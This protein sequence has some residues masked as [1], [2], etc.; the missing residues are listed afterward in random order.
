M[1]GER[2]IVPLGYAAFGFA[3]GVAAGMIIRRTLPAMATTL[4]LFLGVRIAFTYLIRSHLLAP[5]HRVVPLDPANMGFGSSNGGPDNLMPG[6]PNLPNAWI[7]STRIVDGSGRS[8]T[9]TAL[10]NAC[11]QLAQPLSGP[12]PGSGHDVHVQIPA[13]AQTTLQSCVTKLSSTYHVA[14]TYQPAHRYW[15]FQWYE[16]AIFVVAALLLSGLCFWWIR[17]RPS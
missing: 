14:V 6:P 3:L 8:L 2:N 9:S 12:P 11:P 4:A 10:N 17:R 7:Y 16:T 13:D 1:F 15:L 5:L